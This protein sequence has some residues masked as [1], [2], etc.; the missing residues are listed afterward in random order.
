MELAKLREP[1]EARDIEWRIGQSGQSNGKIWAKVLAYV[2]ARAIMNRLDEVCGPENWQASYR[3]EGAGVMCS[4]SL[5]IDR[6]DD[7]PIWVTKE[8]GAEPTEFEPYKGAISGALKR[9]ASAWGIG[10]YL[11]N[12]PEGWAVIHKEKGE[13]RHYAKTKDG[14]AFFWSPPRLPAEFLPGGAAEASQEPQEPQDG[15]SRGPRGPRSTTAQHGKIH[16]LRREMGLS[17][18]VYRAEL[19]RSYHARSTKELNRDQAGELISRLVKKQKADL[20]RDVAD[21]FGDGGRA[22]MLRKVA[23]GHWESLRRAGWKYAVG[24]GAVDLRKEG[25]VCETPDELR[26]VLEAMS[27]EKELEQMIV[28]LEA[29]L[30][31]IS[32]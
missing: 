15:P 31:V 25:L 4:L 9:A 11:Y 3:H 2:T 23:L 26:E 16:A 12:L 1:F 14:T 6:E 24:G 20:E 10:R 13:G 27:D 30:R 8:D 21:T 32:F 18:D 5:R 29:L 17:E 7:V 22:E 28:R 19:F